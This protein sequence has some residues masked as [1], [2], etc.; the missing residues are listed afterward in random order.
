[1][2]LDALR[3]FARRVLELAADRAAGRLVDA[4]ERAI[5][6][7]PA[8]CSSSGEITAVLCA[9][10]GRAM[11]RAARRLVCACGRWEHS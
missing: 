10:C 4:A 1:M 9:E 7:A 11:T 8:S 2:I 3:A 6:P 5:A